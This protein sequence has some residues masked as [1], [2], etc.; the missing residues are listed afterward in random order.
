[1]AETRP[2]TS[3]GSDGAQPPQHWNT[4]MS[5]LVVAFGRQ[6]WAVAQLSAC[7][8][9]RATVEWRVTFANFARYCTFAL[10]P[11]SALSIGAPRAFVVAAAVTLNSLCKSAL[12]PS[13]T[14]VNFARYCTF[15]LLPD[16]RHDAYGVP[17][18]R[19]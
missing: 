5:A 15:A 3:G 17:S 13:F 16:V 7:N 10:L 8:C 14:F 11:R 4:L 12:V 1:M 18:Y 9:A 19:M 2:R 6:T